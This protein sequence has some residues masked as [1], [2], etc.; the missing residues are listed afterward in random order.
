[1]RSEHCD[2][3]SIHFYAGGFMCEL[4]TRLCSRWSLPVGTTA[5]RDI[6][7]WTLRVGAEAHPPVLIASPGSAEVKTPEKLGLGYPPVRIP[8]TPFQDRYG[9]AGAMPLDEITSAARG[10]RRKA[11]RAFAAS[12]SSTPRTSPAENMN[13]PC[14]SLGNGPATS[15][16]GIAINS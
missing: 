7:Q 4:S 8:S 12:L 3:V 15:M 2:S 13:L 5:R 6:P 9:T 11:I 10:V 14:S 1:M 16:P